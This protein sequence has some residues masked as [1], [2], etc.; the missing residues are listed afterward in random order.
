MEYMSGGKPY[1]GIIRRCTCLEPSLR[2]I[3]VRALREMIRTR[4]RMPAVFASA[5]VFLGLAVILAVVL[6]RQKSGIESRMEDK[7]QSYNEGMTDSL[8]REKTRNIQESIKQYEQDPEPLFE[9]AAALM[10]QQEYKEFAIAYS[11]A[12]YKVAVHYADSIYNAFPLALD[13]SPGN[14]SLAMANLFSRYRRVLDSLANALPSANTLP[15]A[16]RDSP[17]LEIEKIVNQ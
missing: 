7:I 11:A 6:Q 13:G 9:R 2:P 17:S 14:E 16:A 3:D 12:Y 10:K 4:D 5:A 8:S 15:V 1:R